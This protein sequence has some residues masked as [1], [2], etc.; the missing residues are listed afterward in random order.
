[1]SLLG[2][3][4]CPRLLPVSGLIRLRSFRLVTLKAALGIKRS[5]KAYKKNAGNN[6]Q[7]PSPGTHP[8]VHSM[9]S[10][11]HTGL[12]TL[13]LFLESIELIETVSYNSHSQRQFSSPKP[14]TY[15][16]PAKS[17]RAPN[18][19]HLGCLHTCTRVA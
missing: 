13:T 4:C 9:L 19:S 6:V 10:N 14:G 18:A 2:C 15:Y 12:L 1:M 16:L 3:R 8:S 7:E 17:N 11:R 5:W